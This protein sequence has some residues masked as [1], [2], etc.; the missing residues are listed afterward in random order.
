MHLTRQE[1]RILKGCHFHG[2]A[3]I[4]KRRACVIGR[5]SSDI[6][7]RGPGCRHCCY[8]HH[9]VETSSVCP[10]PLSTS[11]S[12]RPRRHHSSPPP[13]PWETDSVAA[14]HPL[15]PGGL[16]RR[17]ATLSRC[18]SAARSRLVLAA[19]WPRRRSAGHHR[20]WRRR[21]AEGPAAVEAVAGCSL[22]RR[23]GCA[24]ARWSSTVWCSRLCAATHRQR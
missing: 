6:C 3:G 10:T 16:R 14:A 9:A 22:G 7:R 13:P 2:P 21:P 17:Q 24:V 19:D 12:S 23:C 20:G 4:C 15:R 18:L 1:T 11:P 5:R 8:R